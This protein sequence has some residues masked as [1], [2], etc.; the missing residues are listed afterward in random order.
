MD[1]IPEI[2]R[3]MSK[4]AICN[5]WQGWYGWSRSGKGNKR[6]GAIAARKL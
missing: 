4:G 5:L 3:C 1:L 2:R 6:R